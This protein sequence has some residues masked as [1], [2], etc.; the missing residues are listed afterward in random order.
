MIRISSFKTAAL[1]AALL[2]LGRTAAVAGEQAEPQPLLGYLQSELDYSMENLVAEDGTKPYYLAYTVYEE[3]TAVVSASLGAVAQD[4][5]E[6]GRKLNIDLDNTHQI[7]GRGAAQAS[8][9]GNVPLAMQDNEASIR[10][11]LWYHTDEVFRDAVKRLDQIK[12]DLKVR[13]RKENK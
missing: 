13:V 1:L 9:S 12:T 4:F 6:E 7:R 5:V 3:T 10:Q 8:G 11:T 2:V